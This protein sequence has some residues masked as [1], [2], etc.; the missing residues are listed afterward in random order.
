MKVIV[1]GID[2]KASKI[3]VGCADSLTD[4]LE[5]FTYLDRFS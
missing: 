1:I 5:A 4:I 2:K 3:S